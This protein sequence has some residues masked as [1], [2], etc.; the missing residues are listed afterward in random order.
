MTENKEKISSFTD[1]IAWKESHKLVIMIYEATKS[2]PKE[3]I[4]GLYNGLIKK[5]RSMITS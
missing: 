1:L 4:F 2:F 5:S 3:E